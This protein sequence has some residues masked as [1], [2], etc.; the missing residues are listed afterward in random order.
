MLQQRYLAGFTA[1]RH[2]LNFLSDFAKQ[3]F[4]ETCFYFVCNTGVLVVM[5][6]SIYISFIY[7]I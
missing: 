3:L 7:F 4:C 6:T 2:C 5:E 1:L